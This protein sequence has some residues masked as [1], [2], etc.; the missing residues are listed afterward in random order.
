M[1]YDC[2]KVFEK[3]VGGMSCSHCVNAVTK[4][5]NE[6]NGVLNVNV[7]LDTKTVKAEYDETQINETQII[8]I[9]EDLGY[10]VE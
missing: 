1:K 5:L 6:T 10:S 8:E 2:M 3:K 4:A 9:I 7:S